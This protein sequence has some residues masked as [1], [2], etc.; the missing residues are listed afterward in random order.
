LYDPTAWPHFGPFFAAINDHMEASGL[1]NAPVSVP[2]SAVLALLLLWVLVRLVRARKAGTDEAIETAPEQA[3]EVIAEDIAAE[4]DEPAPLTPQTK[5]ELAAEPSETLDLEPEAEPA[6][7]APISETELPEEAEPPAPE[8]EVAPEPAPEA[9]PE[10]KLSFF[11]RLRQGLSKTA[12]GLVG[13]IDQLVRGRKIDD[14][15]FEDLEEI[16]FTADL[17]PTTADKLLTTLEE[18]AREE[19]IEDAVEIKEILK[20]EMI[21]ILA[22]HQAPLDLEGHKPFVIMVVGVNGVGKTTTIGKV[23]KMMSDSGK[24]VIFGAADTF[25]AAA[26]EQLQIWA[27]RAGADIVRQKAG[28]DPAAV[29]YDA[30]QAAVNREVDVAIIDT[31][32]RLHTQQNLM[33]ELKKVK[34]VMG[35]V[36]PGAPHEVLLVLDAN[37]GQNAISQAKS[38]HE[39]L[40]LTG[41]ILTKLDGTAKGGCIVGI[42]DEL[43]VPVRYIGIGEQMDDM[44][45]FV[46]EDFVK[47]LFEAAEG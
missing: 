26:D 17:G 41:I 46:A 1:I 28:A 44:R 42:C 31:A 5:I 35:K 40:G 3:A 22:P 6:P 39:A 24:K 21:K 32:G 43:A 36:L 34:R 20:E 12:G 16:L 13:R 7:D 9:P 45:P 30:V 38:F 2:L 37:T 8:I 29:A 11:A 25:R 19:K 33:E 23:A 18:R 27:D 15:F 14:E 4:A 47:A 10:K